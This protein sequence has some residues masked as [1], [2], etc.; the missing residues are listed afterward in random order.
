MICENI[1]PTNYKNWAQYIIPI[2]PSSFQSLSVI[3]ER[4]QFDQNQPQCFPNCCSLLLTTLLIRSGDYWWVSYKAEGNLFGLKAKVGEADQLVPPVQG[5][6][7]YDGNKWS[8]DPTLECSRDCRTV[9]AEV[10]Y[11]AKAGDIA[12][13]KQLQQMDTSGIILMS[14]AL[15]HQIHHQISPTITILPFQAHHCFWS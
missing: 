14:S 1:K 10:D 15:Y 3:Q 8:S 12:G 13:I 2:Y 11:A 4:D 7:F 6:Q 9:A 5:W